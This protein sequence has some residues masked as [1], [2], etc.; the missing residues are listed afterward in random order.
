[1]VGYATSLDDSCFCDD[2]IITVQKGDSFSLDHTGGENEIYS[3]N[4]S[5]TKIAKLFPKDDSFCLSC[6][7]FMKIAKLLHCEEI[8]YRCACRI[9]WRSSD[10]T[11]AEREKTE[12]LDSAWLPIPLCVDH[13]RGKCINITSQLFTNTP[14]PL[15]VSAVCEALNLII[16]HTGLDLPHSFFNCINS[17]F[18][19]EDI[20][21]V[22]KNIFGDGIS[23][24]NVKFKQFFRRLNIQNEIIEPLSDF[25]SLPTSH[26]DNCIGL[27]IDAKRQYFSNICDDFLKC[28]KLKSGWR[29]FC[30]LVS[31]HTDEFLYKL[32]DLSQIFV[33]AENV[34]SVNDINYLSL[35]ELHSAFAFYEFRLSLKTNI[36]RNRLRQRILNKQIIPS[37]IGADLNI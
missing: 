34:N 36:S 16:A 1:M 14:K 28:I 19:S 20:F 15:G 27:L 13:Y 29:S 17:V 21:F 6:S 3:I 26:N 22:F 12:F 31:K 8:K 24:S 9:Y 2:I 10:L 35:Y 7:A 11:Y 33:A 30:S 5:F 18:C 32:I 4:R 37:K 25:A 23:L